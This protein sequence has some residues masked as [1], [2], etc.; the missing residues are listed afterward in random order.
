MPYRRVIL[1]SFLTSLVISLGWQIYTTLH[2]VHFLDEILYLVA[3]FHGVSFVVYWIRRRQGRNFRPARVQSWAARAAVLANEWAFGFLLVVALDL[4]LFKAG[5][6]ERRY[7]LS[8][9]L[10]VVLLG[11]IVG[12]S[13]LLRRRRKWFF[14][15]AAF[16]VGS[17][18]LGMEIARSFRP[19]PIDESIVLHPPFGSSFMTLN[20]GN[21]PLQNFQYQSAP[22]F[23]LGVF[24]VTETPFR[25]PSLS[26]AGFHSQT[27]GQP[28]LAPADGVIRQ[29]V[30]DLPDMKPGQSDYSHLLGNYIILEISSDRY[31]YLANLQQS[32]IRVSLGDAVEAGQPIARA[33]SSGKT[34]MSALFMTIVDKPELFDPTVTSIPFY[35]TGVERNGDAKDTGPFFPVRNDFFVPR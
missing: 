18:V 33:G 2:F 12:F 5:V 8:M 20:G 7:L 24:S 14:V 15:Q 26:E 29:V 1:E 16:L 13:W 19:P 34:T 30:S 28:V 11:M 21:T 4:S 25:D 31:L 9:G 6:T 22:R 35:F 3:G 23:F 17:L 32:S 27:L 10:W